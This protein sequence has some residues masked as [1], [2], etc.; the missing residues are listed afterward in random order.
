M[1][2]EAPEAKQVAERLSKEKGKTITPA[3]VLI[4]WN[5]YS[6]HS[7]IPKSVTSSRIQSNFEEVELSEQDYQEVSKIGDKPE[8]YNVPWTA[9]KSLLFPFPLDSRY[10]GMQEHGLT[11]HSSLTEKPRWDIQLFG[12]YKEKPARHFAIVGA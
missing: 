2:V 5:K 8:R 9:G 4:A 12:D 3:Q 11:C 10:S 7:V 1:L 6:G